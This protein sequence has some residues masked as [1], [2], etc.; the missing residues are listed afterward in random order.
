VTEPVATSPLGPLHVSRVGLGCNNFGGRLDLGA[1]RAVV[2][3][4]LDCGVTFFDTADIY[5]GRGGSE[6]LLG[7]ILEGRR[8]RVVLATKFGM[9]MGD[10][11][12]A[13]GTRQYARSAVEA[14]LRRLR[15][16][17]VDLLY[18]HRPD[19]TTPLA[20]TL[21]VLDELVREG[22]A[23][24]IGCSNL[25]VEQLDVAVRAA[26]EGGL[27]PLSALQNEHSLLRR[28]AEHDVLPRCRELGV[29]FVP[30]FPLASGLLTGKYRRGQPPPPG[31]RL[32]HRPEALTHQAF[33]TIERLEAFAR[34]R[35]R[36]LLELAIAGLASQPGV[37][38][39]IAGATTPEQVRAN[40]AAGS[41]QLDDEDLRDLAALRP[42]AG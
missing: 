18:Y 30:Y 10:G 12:E 42:D 5:G 17:R 15:T 26:A 41:W 3:A 14:S 23:L 31:T 1:T 25:T 13:R 16:D 4:A 33:T 29:G 35:G 9:D 32:E 27:A 19:G 28:E 11:V 21:R 22:K 38:S 40:A 20:E 7:E 36:T 2:D 37:S 6:R 24:A 8:D 34:D 39:V